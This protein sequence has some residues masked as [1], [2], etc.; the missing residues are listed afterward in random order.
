MCVCVSDVALF[1]LLIGVPPFMY[2]LCVYTDGNI[3][4]DV[5]E[6]QVHSSIYWLSSGVARRCSVL[7]TARSGRT[8]AA[9]DWP[10]STSWPFSGS[11]MPFE[12]LVGSV[13]SQL[14]CYGLSLTLDRSRAI[15]RVARLLSF[16][17]NPRSRESAGELFPI[18][19]L[20]R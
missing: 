1:T 19:I 13:S 6:V 3:A 11:W 4:L 15:A 18:P 12:G 7:I 14:F 9:S 16:H 10:A 17:C 20:C 8:F 2:G 5:C